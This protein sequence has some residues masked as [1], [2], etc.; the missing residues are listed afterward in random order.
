VCVCVCF[1][2]GCHAASSQRWLTRRVKISCNV[3]VTDQ[4]AVVLDVR[5]T[6]AGQ[7]QVDVSLQRREEGHLRRARDTTAVKTTTPQS[8]THTHTQPDDDGW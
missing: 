5:V 2:V 3:G 4:E 6:L 7:A 8:F 1:V